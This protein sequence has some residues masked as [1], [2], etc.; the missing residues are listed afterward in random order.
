MGKILILVGVGLLVLVGIVVAM[1]AGTYNSLVSKREA[2][3]SQW[4]GIES[5]L[6]RRA[7]LIPNLVAAVQGSFTQEQVVFGE[8]ARARAGLVSALGSGDRAAVNTANNQLTSAL[9]GLNVLVTSEAYPQ[10][11][12][13]ENV[14][15]LMAELAGTENRINVSRGDYNAAVR[16][17]NQTLQSFPTNIIGGM[18]GFK[19]AEYFE[20]DPGSRQAPK[21]QFPDPRQQQPAPAPAPAR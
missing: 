17:Y 11:Q 5:A 6:Q 14:R 15:G 2:V 10:L 19:Q 4:A 7:D 18:M 9:Q 1:G 20:A 3:D 21:V 13:N 8:I 16:D 12:S